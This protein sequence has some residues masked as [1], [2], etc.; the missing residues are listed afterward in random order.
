[1]LSH[2][3]SSNNL[4]LKLIKTCLLIL[5]W[6]VLQILISSLPK[7]STSGHNNNSSL[8]KIP[9][10]TCLTDYHKVPNSNHSLKEMLSG[11]LCKSILLR[12][13]SKIRIC[14]AN[15][16][17]NHKGRTVN[18]RKDLEMSGQ[19]EADSLTFQILRQVISR[20]WKPHRLGLM[21]TTAIMAVETYYLIAKISTNYGLQHKEAQQHK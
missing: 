18:N 20:D 21:S 3:C 7:I 9:A 13:R 12:A 19:K 5:T 11:T 14:L 8:L 17:N 2:L 6:V 16:I 10:S 1:M 15:L 4:L